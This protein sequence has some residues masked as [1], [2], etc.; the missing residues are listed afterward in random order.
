MTRHTVDTTDASSTLEDGITRRSLVATAAVVAASGCVGLGG[1]QRGVADLS[2]YNPGSRTRDVAVTVTGDEE[3][4]VDSRVTIPP[5][6][7][8][9]L[10]NRVAMAQRVSVAVR[11][12]GTTVTHDWDVEESLTATVGDDVRFQTGSDGERRRTKRTD[13]RVDVRIVAG[14]ADHTATVR[15]TRDGERAFAVDRS[16]AAGRHVTYHGR[17]DATGTVDVTVTTR[18]GSV[19]ERV[20]LTDATQVTV[21]LDGTS[22]D[23]TRAGTATD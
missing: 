15:V 14:G 2:L 23:T 5:R 7:T 1:Q 19:D 4:I 17:V 3:A 12:D 22:V 10:Q 8:V 21:N 16:F 11:T 13:G 6:A 18:A 20:R 9:E